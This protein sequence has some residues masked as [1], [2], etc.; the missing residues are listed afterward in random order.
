MHFGRGAELEVESGRKQR[1]RVEGSQAAV[2][3][4]EDQSAV[5]SRFLCLPALPATLQGLLGLILVAL[6]LH[7]I[8][9]PDWS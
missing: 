2:F 9:F 8:V 7:N 3:I 6:L 5:N 1:R 4:P